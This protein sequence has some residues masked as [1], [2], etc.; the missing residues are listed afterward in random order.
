MDT[1]VLFLQ[2][3]RLQVTHIPSEFVQV[4]SLKVDPHTLK[5]VKTIK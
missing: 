3:V 5:L 1:R 2:S 4:L